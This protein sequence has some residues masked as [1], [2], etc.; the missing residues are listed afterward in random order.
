MRKY[1]MGSFKRELLVGF[2]LVAIL[3]LLI[4]SFF[5]IKLFETKIE[6]DRQSEITMQLEFVEDSLTE[7]FDKLDITINELNQN[8]L[9]IQSLYEKNEENRKKTYN[10]L[11][12]TTIEL[13]KVAQFELYSIGGICKYSTSINVINTRLP[14][15]WGILS[16]AGK[17][18]DN[19]VIRGENEY[20]NNN[21]DIVLRF[22]RAITDNLGNCIGYT[23][24]GM[25]TSDFKTLL[26]DK[27]NPR[28][29]IAIL[30]GKWN[31]IYSSEGSE[32]NSI[33]Y[34]LREKLIKDGGI[35]GLDR[36]HKLYIKPIGDT[37]LFIALQREEVFTTD[38]SKTMYSVCG[39][40]VILSLM[41][42]I[43]VSIKL[44]G[45]FVKPIHNM[46]KAMHKLEE[47]D[48]DTR[49]KVERTDEFGH[50][51]TN[52]NIMAEKLKD[53][54]DYRIKQQ[55][56]LNASII[57]TMQAQLK[58]HFIYNTLDTI[59][60]V[61]K[62]NHISEITVLVTGLAKILRTSISS[63]QFVTLKEEL[64]L[65][66]CYVDIQRIR[67]SDKFKYKAE[68]QEGLEDVIVPKFVIQP[69]VENAVIHAFDDQDDGNILV[70]AY[71][72]NGKLIV[73]ISD[74]GCGIDAETVR[75][76]NSKKRLE[77]HIGLY[78]VDTIIRLRHG[79]PF[80]IS[81]ETPEM[82]GTVVTIIMPMVSGG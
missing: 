41:L 26:E 4:C 59:K 52:F 65:V 61:A 31:T 19:L 21:K 13:R 58:P 35:E 70:T 40:M 71:E 29:H 14:T 34:I 39:I 2:I 11:Y 64:N 6:M 43:L 23:V 16:A 46:S 1:I 75:T 82:G 37:G 69:I 25:K 15:Y 54:V 72:E 12:T 32:E 27:Y 76:L 62:A 30:D 57:A 42:C 9:V 50:L 77:G 8:K 53:N 79:E 80:G 55:Q 49:I 5:M 38:I 68:I 22:A 44:S 51:A 17:N 36:E 73:K 66:Q 56:E 78:N 28:D 45:Y 7:F 33:G 67:F 74:D 60:W 3:P 20:D 24:I 47:G 48:L 81:V 10:A 18:P 63:N